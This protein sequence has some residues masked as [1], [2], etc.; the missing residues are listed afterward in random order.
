MFRRKLLDKLN[1]LVINSDDWAV[2]LHH[3]LEI[4]DRRVSGLEP[5]HPAPPEDLSRDKNGHP[6]RRGDLIQAEHWGARDK[7]N[8]G[9]FHELEKDAGAV[10]V[11]A[12]W[13]DENGNF[14]PKPTC[15][16]KEADRITF[17]AHLP[18]QDC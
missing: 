15:V 7:P 5:P 9:I 13:R 12:R 6:L 18:A 11:C 1:D 2:E 17:I 10:W 3:V 14:K 16:L 4:L 8:W